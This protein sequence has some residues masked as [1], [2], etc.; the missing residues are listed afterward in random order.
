MRRVFHYFQHFI[1]YIQVIDTGHLIAA[2]GDSHSLIEDVVPAGYSL[3]Y[4]VAMLVE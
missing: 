3:N 2:S 4:V 1:L